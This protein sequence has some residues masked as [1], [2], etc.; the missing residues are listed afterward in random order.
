MVGKIY[1]NRHHWTDGAPEF[2]QAVSL[3]PDNALLRAELGSAYLN[4]DLADKALAAFDKAVQL[5]RSPE[6]LNDVSYE[7]TEKN[8]HLPRALQYAQSAVGDNTTRPHTVPLAPT[9]M[10]D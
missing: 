8:V 2:E 6:I 7:L 5:D 9:E 10:P 1:A 4:M 3:Q